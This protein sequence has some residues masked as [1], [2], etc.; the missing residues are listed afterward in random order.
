MQLFRRNNRQN[1]Q[2]DRIVYANKA[3]V[4]DHFVDNVV[5]TY[6]LTIHVSLVEY[7]ITS[8]IK[9]YVE[10]KRIYVTV[11]EVVV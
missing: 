6:V 10:T 7:T 2:A 9:K 8:F 5:I 4:N 11:F 1:T 3:E